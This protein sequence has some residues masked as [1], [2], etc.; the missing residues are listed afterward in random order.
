MHVTEMITG[1]YQSAVWFFSLL[2]FSS[3][4]SFCFCIT[5]KRVP[6]LLAAPANSETLGN[7]ASLS[8]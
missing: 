1:W 5:L 6:F 7:P 3:A 2:P 8:S 4:G